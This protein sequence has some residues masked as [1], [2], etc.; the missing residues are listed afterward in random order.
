MIV[1][2]VQADPASAPHRQIAAAVSYRAVQS[3]PSF[4]RAGELLGMVST[5]FRQ[6]RRP[7][8]RERELPD[9]YVSIAAEMI[10]RT[11]AEDRLPRDDERLKAILDNSPNLIFLKDPGGHYLLVNRE[12]EKVN[13]FTPQPIQGER[14]DEIF[15]RALAASPFRAGGA[16][17]SLVVRETSQQFLFRGG[18]SLAQRQRAMWEKSL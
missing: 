5:H 10:E 6:P 3:T 9:L 14:D 7:A 16:K 11:Q 15:P 2:D 1:E 18:W 13:H 17:S 8:P 12:F 4:A